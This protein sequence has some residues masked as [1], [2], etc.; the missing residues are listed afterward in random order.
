[1][2]A[3]VKLEKKHFPVLLNELTSIISP[4]YSGTFIDCTFGQGG[5]TE[6]ILKNKNNKVIAIDRDKDTSIRALKF[7]DKFKNNFVYKNIKFSQINTINLEKE[8]LKAVIF[9]L[10]YSTNQILDQ[11]KGLSFN[12]KGKLNMKM[13]LNEYSAHEVINKLESKDLE[14]IFKYYGEENKFKKISKKICEIRKNKVIKTEDLVEIINSVKYKNFSKIHNSTKIFQSLR[15]FVNKEISELIYG[16]INAF[17]ILPVGGMIVVVSFQS[18][19]DRIVK[20]FF[21]NFSKNKNPSRYFPNNVEK[22]ILFNLIKN[23]PIFPAK[24]EQKIN[25]SS[26]S[27]KL[28]YVIKIN[29][30]NNFDEFIKRFH[31][32]LDIENLSKKL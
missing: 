8:K 22:R 5:Y 26:R 2:K 7:K 6:Q 25:P 17:K 23:K 28:R 12:S 15:I 31:N 13:G 11:K 20:Y 9:D 16:L 3:T 4:L 19:E 14:K 32:L 21:K 30:T 27:A 29:D 10:G 18:I 1:M 24:K